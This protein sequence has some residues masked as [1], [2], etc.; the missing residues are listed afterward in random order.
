MS[1][2]PQDRSRQRYSQQQRRRPGVFS[3]IKLRLLIG[4]AIVFFSV[5]SF[6]NKGEINPVTG[7]KQRVDMSI[8]DEIAQGIQSVRAMGPSSLNRRAQSHVDQ[9]GYKLVKNLEAMLYSQGKEL[10]Y[11]FEFHLLAKP[12]VNAFALPGGQVF[13]TET[14]YRA[15][16]GS[17]GRESDKHSARIAGVLGHEI[18]HVIHRHGS[19]RMAKGNLISGIVGAAGVAGGD[20]SSRNVAAYVGNLASMKYGR[21]DELESD[22]WGIDLMILSGYHPSYLLDVMEVL[23]ASKGG[24]GPPEFL[25]T[26]PSSE[27]RIARIKEIIKQKQQKIDQMQSQAILDLN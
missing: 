14:L 17:E 4:G 18:G 9:I 3:G 8:Q 15:L 10:P 24:A 22:L 5:V 13:I 27:T 20:M 21:E 1:Y 23:K 16:E 2:S 25:S 6:M 12:E 26:H 19:E 7:E 11:P